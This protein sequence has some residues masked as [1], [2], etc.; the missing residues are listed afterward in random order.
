MKPRTEEAINNVIEHLELSDFE[1][2][3]F[4]EDIRIVCETLR[5]LPEMESVLAHGGL[6][7]DGKG[8]WLKSGDKVKYV[9]RNNG[10]HIGT[11]DF[12]TNNLCWYLDTDNGDCLYLAHDFF[13]VEHFEKLEG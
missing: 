4:C 5:K 12:D 11:V 8:N 7:R 9:D 1:E 3:S 10:V 6:V 2:G 13:E